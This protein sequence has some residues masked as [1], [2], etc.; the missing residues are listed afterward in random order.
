M[1]HHITTQEMDS[2]AR[3]G[4]DDLRASL[5]SNPPEG[6]DERAG[7]CLAILS[8]STRRMSA[9]TNRAAV[10]FKIVKELGIV[11]QEAGEILKPLLPNASSRENAKAQ[12]LLAQDKSTTSR[13]SQRRGVRKG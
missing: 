12:G 4:L 1:N 7:R 8:Q 10:A 13:G 6:A 5:S 2:I 11:S 9:E 3:I